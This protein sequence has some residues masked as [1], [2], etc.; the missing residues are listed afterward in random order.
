MDRDDF[1]HL[2]APYPDGA[3]V[4]RLAATARIKAGSIEGE[5]MLPGRNDGRRSFETMAILQIETCGSVRLHG[6]AATTDFRSRHTLIP[7]LYR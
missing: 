6:P 2:A 7:Y 5:G 1:K 3:L 4:G